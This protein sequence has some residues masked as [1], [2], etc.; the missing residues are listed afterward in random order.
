MEYDVK[1]WHTFRFILTPKEL[2]RVLEPFHLVVDNAHVPAGYRETPKAE[3]LE[4]YRQLY[5]KLTRGERLTRQGD[6]PLF[7]HTGLTTDLSRCPYGRERLYES[8]RFLSAVFAAPCVHLAPFTL[9]V[10]PEG[11]MVSLRG[12]YLQSPQNTVGLE[13]SFP[14]Q[15]SPANRGFGS[16][17]GLPSHR[18]FLLLKEQVGAL[19]HGLRFD[20]LGRTYR[21]AVKISDAAQAD[22]SR[23]YAVAQFSNE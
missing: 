21:P 2:T 10:S 13:T 6:W 12:S 5:A 7:R 14:R 22:F 19:S 23:F 17:E 1:G 15:F 8:K 4:P 3:F 11:R 18:D 20:L 16:T 9:S